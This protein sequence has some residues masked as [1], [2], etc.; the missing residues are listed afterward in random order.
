MGVKNRDRNY[1]PTISIRQSNRDGTE[2]V[3]IVDSVTKYSEGINEY[4]VGILNAATS[5]KNDESEAASARRYEK[6]RLKKEG[7]YKA[8]DGIILRRALRHKTPKSAAEYLIS[9]NFQGHTL[10]FNQDECWILE[11]GRE[12]KDQEENTK[13]SIINPEHEWSALKYEY[14]L[15]QINKKDFIVR[16]NHGQFMPWIGYQKD[17]EDAKMLLSRKSSE[18]R[19]ESAI[20]NIENANT[21]EEM[22]QAISDVSNKNSQLNPVRIGDYQNKTKLKTTGQLCLIPKKRELIY[23]PIWCYS[24]ATNFDK[25]NSQKTDTFFTLK[26]FS[27]FNDKKVNELFSFE[28]YLN[29]TM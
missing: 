19:H 25:I 9:K 14:S 1:K 12:K 3:Y 28:R 2:A 23:I 5:V 13:K 29:S 20:K 10:I 21:P 16:T 11:G 18:A 22:I 27:P 26:A 4:G 8:P 7:A 17:S 15:K 24:D 6:G